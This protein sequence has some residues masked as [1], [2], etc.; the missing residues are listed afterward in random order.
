M[1][2]PAAEAK[3]RAAEEKRINDLASRIAKEAE[4]TLQGWEDELRMEASFRDIQREEQKRHE[5]ERIASLIEAYDREQE[6]AIR[7]GAEMMAIEADR[8]A[9]E[10]RLRNMSARQRAA[11]IAGEFATLT[12]IVSSGSKKM[13][14]LNKLATIANVALTLP[15][16]ISDAFKWGN[17]MG[18]PYVG[19]AF[20]AVAAAVGLAHIQMARSQQF[21]GGGA[22]PSVA[23]TPAPAVTPVSAQGAATT[24]GR[25]TVINLQGDTFGRKQLRELIE[26][27]NETESGGGRL[28]LA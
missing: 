25:T 26:Q 14:E 5:D 13:F 28:I 3:R 22:A 27:L 2:N 9:E 16:K 12:S 15:E 19:A 18:G 24:Q 7:H 23:A 8:Y 11:S 20:A 4:L 21:S 17:K 6:E 10:Q 1:E